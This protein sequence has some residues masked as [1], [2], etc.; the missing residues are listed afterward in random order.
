MQLESAPSP[1]HVPPILVHHVERSRSLHQTVVLLTVEE[2]VTPVVSEGSRYR[3]ITLSE[4]FYRLIVSFG[5]ME[6]PLLLPVLQQVS[7]RE[8]IPLEA[9][10]ATYYIGHETI[11]AKNGGTQRVPE[12][13]FSYLNRNAVHEE[14]RYGMP[15]QQVVEIGTQLYL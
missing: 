12:A 10:D 11:I 5:Y 8:H 3:V 1:D 13:V 14:R 4:G 7:R 2:S 15:A 6:E 9:D